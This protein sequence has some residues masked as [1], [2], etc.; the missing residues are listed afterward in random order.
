MR[1]APIASGSSGNCIFVGTDT[2]NI[3]I[4]D[5]ISFKRTSEGLKSLGIDIHDI[6]AVLVTHEH[7]DHTQ[8]LGVLSRKLS[9]PIYSTRGTADGIRETSSLGKIDEDLFNYVNADETFEIK[10]LSI[11]PIH[12]SHD[13]N[14][15]T[16]FTLCEGTKKVSVVTDLGTYTDYTVDAIK[17]SDI[18]MLEANHDVSMLEV[19][20]YPYYLKQRILSDHGH[21]SNE[22]SGRLLSSVLHDEVKAIFL[23]HLSK[24]NNIPELAYESVRFEIEAS[25]TKYHG[26]DFEIRVAKRDTPMEIIEI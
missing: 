10:D 7:T 11:K 16:A 24:E 15:P 20:P 1:F 6:D 13:A 25:H 17:N 19:G 21:L 9:I 2:T 8:G 12:I 5:G 18:I 23:G 26:N 22:N 4:D 3:L 14:D